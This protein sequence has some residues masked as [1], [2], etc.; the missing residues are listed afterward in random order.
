MISWVPDTILNFKLG[1]KEAF[2]LHHWEIGSQFL[3]SFSQCSGLPYYRFYYF[4]SGKKLV[5]IQYKIRS[6]ENTANRYT[7]KRKIENWPPI[8]QLCR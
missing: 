8:S 6:L 5:A 7:F 2:Y 1:F 3:F 4:S